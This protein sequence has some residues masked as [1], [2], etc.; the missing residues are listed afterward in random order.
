MMRENMLRLPFTS[1]LAPFAQ[2]GAP[3]Q[4]TT[5]IERMHSTH[6]CQLPEGI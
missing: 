3:H 1:E 6:G 5:G 2:I 4:K